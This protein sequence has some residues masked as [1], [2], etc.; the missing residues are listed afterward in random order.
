MGTKGLI[1]KIMLVETMPEEFGTMRARV[2]RG[3]Y[4]Q[5]V[6]FQKN[7]LD[8]NGRRGKKPGLFLI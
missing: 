8:F 3:G 2:V 4:T 6:G 1:N 7:V 5:R